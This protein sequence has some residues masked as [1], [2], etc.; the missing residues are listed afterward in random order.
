ML[1]LYKLFFLLV[2]CSSLNASTII[3]FNHIKKGVEDNN[4]LL[5]IG[6]IQGDE[7][8]GF[9]AASLL[10]TH[11]EI[12]K[13]SVWVVPNLNFYSII[14]RSRGPY[15]DM[16][17]KFA[18]LSKKDPE[19]KTV[20]RI[21]NLIKDDRVKLIVNLHDVSGFYRE[22]YID[23]NHQP[24]KWGQCSII[25]QS[26]LNVKYYRN[27]SDI[28]N[29]VVEHVNNNLLRSEDIY[30]Q[31]NTRTKDGD[32]EMEKSLT[33]F[34]TRNGKSAFGNEASKNL[35]TH[36]RVYYHL[37]ALEKYME[38]MGIKYKRKFDLTSEG[39]YS[40]INDGLSISL[41]DGKINLPL[42]GIKRE[43]NYFPIMKNSEIQYKGSN[44]L[45]RIVKSNN[46]YSVHYGNR[47]LLKLKADYLEFDEP[48]SSVNFM[49]DGKDTDV[50]FGSIIKVDNEF[51]VSNNSDYRVNVIGYTNKS[52]IETDIQI[53]KAKLM[54][55]FSVDKIGGLYRVEFYKGKKFVGMVLVQFV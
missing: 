7:P 20:E 52:K 2:V 16:N 12:T 46:I 53:S 13:G 21:K 1:K 37:L 17:R 9:I 35:P 3:E 6:G 10:S 11:Y 51:L 39:V 31:H 14:K 54:K 45:M 42:S 5:V 22:Q 18:N 29:K 27:L 23:K 24:H 43:L 40:A 15:G 44:P 30:T 41:Y 19:F 26:K 47:C 32:K 28:S 49:I 38:I 4:T 36:K 48:C 25:D 33:Y 34:A 55:R 50:E 8:G